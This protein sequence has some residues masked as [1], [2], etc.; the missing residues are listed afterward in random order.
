M[1]YCTRCSP[2][3]PTHERNRNYVCS[4]CRRN[5]GIWLEENS[6][7]YLGFGGFPTGYDVSQPF[8]ISHGPGLGRGQDQGQTGFMP[9]STQYNYPVHSHQ[10]TNTQTSLY[11]ARDPDPPDGSILYP[12]ATQDLA[13]GYY[14]QP[15][16]PPPPPLPLHASPTPALP[17]LPRPFLCT[18]CPNS[19]KY[20]KDLNRHLDTVHKAQDDPVYLCRCGKVDTRKDNF[21]RHLRT[22]KGKHPNAHFKCKCDSMFTDK[23]QFSGHFAD[24]HFA[25]P[26]PS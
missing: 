25:R 13:L 12:L 11:S 21:R 26:G 9:S 23:N 4:Y 15:P 19:F 16:P 6:Q 18:M 8:S 14:S 2:M 24:C 3:Y 22:C 7:P 1:S 5:G 20:K 17:D 10:W